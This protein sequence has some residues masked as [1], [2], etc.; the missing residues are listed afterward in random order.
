PQ[1]AAPVPEPVVF[2]AGPPPAFE[3]SPPL[4]PVSLP[5]LPAAIPA[6]RKPASPR[7]VSRTPLGAMLRTRGSIQQAII[8]REVLG[9]PRGLQSLEELRSF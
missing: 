4:T 9:P 7:V 2:E 5:P 1:P 8:L 6:L 3:E